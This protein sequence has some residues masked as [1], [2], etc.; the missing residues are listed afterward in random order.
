MD[1]PTPTLGVLGVYFSGVYTRFLGV[2]KKIILQN[3][4]YKI[5]NK[6][7]HFDDFYF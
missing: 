3:I 7:I 4:F 6:L 2:Q 5:K 1:T